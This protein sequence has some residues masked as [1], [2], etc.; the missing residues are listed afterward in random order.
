MK[1]KM[2]FKNL[3][4]L[5][6]TAKVLLK[7]GLVVS[8]GGLIVLSFYIIEK[9]QILN[10]ILTILG[11]IF[12]LFIGMLTAWLFEPLIKKLEKKKVSRVLG[13]TIVYLSFVLVLVLL[14]WLVVPEFVAQLKELIG[15]VPSFLT[16]AQEFIASFFNKFQNS[17]IDV[18]SIKAQLIAKVEEFAN[19]LSSD[20]L[21]SVINSITKF[22]SEGFNVLL[23]ILIGFYISHDFKKFSNGL[24]NLIPMKYRDDTSKLLENVDEMARGYVSGTLFTSLLVAFLT[25]LGLVIAGVSSPLLFAI[26]C[27]ITNII[28]YFGPY[29]GGIPVVVVAF[30]I[31]PMCGIITL[32]TIVL[33]QFVEGNII[34]P[35]VVGKAVDIHPVVVVLSLLVFEH[36]FGIIGMILA[37]PIVGAIK[38][39]IVFLN[40]KYHFM[41][42]I[43]PDK[44]EVK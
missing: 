37:T 19:N 13:T 24:S 3:N 20:S 17:T 38:I 18:E 9:T 16:K 42:K 40:E 14:L 4:E 12:P 26:F 6:Q 8:I 22:V 7:L 23:G 29:I 27:G 15:Q 39:L 41:N 36:F 21:T 34:H 43:M 35:L 31:S 10:I 33:V 5:I 2:N 11:I 44:I 30:S 28:P 1:E 25:F 32:V